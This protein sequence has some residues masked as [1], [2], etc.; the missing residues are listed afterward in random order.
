MSSRRQIEANRRNAKKST[1]PRSAEGKAIVAK[2]AVRHG[3]L[4]RDVLVRGEDAAEFD[5]FAERLRA[6]LGPVGEIEKFLADRIVVNRWRLRRLGRIE[7]AVLDEDG[8]SPFLIVAETFG[9]STRHKI[10]ALS[11]YETALERSLY[12]AMH[13]LERLQAA[14]AQTLTAMP[15]PADDMGMTDDTGEADRPF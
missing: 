3:L 11:R 7:A 14:R 4:S 1:G 15:L 2:N 9:D 5:G 6:Q 13:E 12:A 8:N 10:M